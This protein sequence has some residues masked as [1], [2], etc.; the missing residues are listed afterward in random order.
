MRNADVSE[1]KWKKNVWFIKENSDYYYYAI[2]MFSIVVVTLVRARVC[3][4]D[5][6]KEI[7]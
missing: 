4:C 5:A 3:V 7:S 1:K 2:G 6:L